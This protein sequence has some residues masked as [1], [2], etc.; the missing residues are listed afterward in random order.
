G[1][2]AAA[3]W[4][5]QT[6]SSF[7]LVLDQQRQLYKTLGLGSSYSKVMGFDCLLRY[8]EYG[9][10]NRGYPDVPPR[11]MEDIY[12]MGGDFLLDEEGNVI[13]SHPS[14]TPLDR[15]SVDHILRA[16]DSVAL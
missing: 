8:S 7:E 4:L 1:L 15:L 11:L 3:L 10:L 12:Q 14:Q 2:D 16:T 13:L 5:Q 6:G 9:V